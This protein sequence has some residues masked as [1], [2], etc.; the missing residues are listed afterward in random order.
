MRLPSGY[1]NLR[2][3]LG[4][5]IR[6]ARKTL[7]LKQEALAADVGI[8]RETL[9]R[10][11]TGKQVPRLQALDVLVA[12]LDIDWDEIAERGSPFCP[13]LIFQEG[14]RG[15][16]LVEIGREIR[17]RRGSASLR[18]LSKRLGLSA[19]QLS[20]LER[21]QILRSRIF[22]DHPD[23]MIFGREHR[24]IEIVDSKLKAFL[25]ND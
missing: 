6:A 4:K 20:R 15:D 7:N 1:S 24:R 3:G 18:T 13:P 21:G 2:R 14:T 23:D 17:L 10:I 19:A 25:E 8:R 12:E 22:R 16:E 9:S 11:E 5:T